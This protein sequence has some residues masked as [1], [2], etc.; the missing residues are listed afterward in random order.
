MGNNNEQDVKE[1]REKLL[2]KYQ[3]IVNKQ[4]IEDIKKEQNDLKKNIARTVNY[5][6][7]LKDEYNKLEKERIRLQNTTI[8]NMH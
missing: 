5:Y 7:K 6:Y 2:P 1:F 8:D 4:Q 3:T